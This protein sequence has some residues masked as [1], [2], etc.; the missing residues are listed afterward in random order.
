MCGIAGYLKVDNTRSKAQIATIVNEMAN[1]MVHRGPDHGDTWVSEEVELGLAH[2][3]LSIID[4]SANGNQPM[5]SEN[6]RYIIVFN[7]EIY[8]HRELRQDLLSRQKV[9]KGHSDTEVILAGCEEWGVEQTITKCVGMFAMALWDIE[10]RQLY[11]VRDRMG[12]KPLY[13]GWQNR[14]FLFSSE[15]KAMRKHPDFQGDIDRNSLTLYFRHNYIPAPYSIY[16]GIFKLEPGTI[17]KLSLSEVLKRANA[18]NYEVSKY[19][20]LKR[21]VE[22]AESHQFDGSAAEAANTL[23]DLLA[24]SIEGQMIAD[25][26]LGAFLSGGVD[27]ST[28]VALM[29]R[30]SSQ[31]VN[32]FCIGFNEHGYNEAAYAKQI[33]KHLGCKHTELYVT[34]RQAKGVIPTIPRLYDEPFADPSQ[35]PTFL[36]SQLARKHV[37]VSISGDAGDELFYGYNVYSLLFK[38]WNIARRINIGNKLVQDI[39][40]ML[41]QVVRNPNQKQLAVLRDLISSGSYVEVYRSMISVCPEPCGL[42]RDAREPATVFSDGELRPDISNKENTVMA[43]DALSYLPDDILVKVDRAAMACS[44]ETRIPLLDHRI[45]EFAFRLPFNIKFRE[46]VSKWPLRQVLYK[47]VPR[48]LIERPKKGFSVPLNSW[49][50]EELREWA[51]DLLDNNTIE[52]DGILNADRIRKYLSEHMNGQQDYSRIIWCLLMFQCWLHQE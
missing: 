5:Y 31:P 3:R 46:G 12:E 44:L 19:W 35:I 26:P 34:P 52:R 50:R 15:L 49:L 2:R 18:A 37:T 47:Y 4:L 16:R 23:E 33:A 45:V 11:L 1:T 42:V 6:R 25:V 17:L 40:L 7:G 27:S 8:N 20:S 24:K 29:Q 38:R 43:L 30:L 9:F 48:K 28:I 32:T 22:N 14:T 21:I 36:V 39:I 13:Y 41:A 51:Y 10:E